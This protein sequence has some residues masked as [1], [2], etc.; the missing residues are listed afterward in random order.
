MKRKRETK[1]E[2]RGEREKKVATR[3]GVEK[4][5]EK[6]EDKIKTTKGNEC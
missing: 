3:R 5:E 6:E 1:E 4:F 2:M